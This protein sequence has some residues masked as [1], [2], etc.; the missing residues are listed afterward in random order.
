MSIQPLHVSADRTPGRGRERR[1]AVRYPGN[2]D[3]SCHAYAPSV[4][5]Y[6]GWVRDISTTGIALLLPCEFEPGAPLTLELENPALGLVRVVPA[7]VVHSIAVPL[8]DRWLHGCVFD[9]PLTEEELRA[10]AE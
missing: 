6:P 5:L 8:D 3:A 1:V 7:R 10:F 9:E 4:G 2:P